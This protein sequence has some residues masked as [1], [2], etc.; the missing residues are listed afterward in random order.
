M[1]WKDQRFD[2]VLI[3][4]ICQGSILS[5]APPV[6]HAKPWLLFSN[7]ASADSRTHMT[8]RVSD[9]GGE[10]WP[11]S[12]LIHAGG[13]AYSDMVRL[14]EHEVGCLYE[15]DGYKRITLARLSLEWLRP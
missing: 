11:V 12:K 8:V 4:P 1:T 14:E 5:L 13:S 2:P 6:D 9:D 3:E 10:T 7:P 15:K